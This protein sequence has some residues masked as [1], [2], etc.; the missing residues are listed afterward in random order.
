[1]VDDIR[2]DLLKGQPLGFIEDKFLLGFLP[3]FVFFLVF[4]HFSE[5]FRDAS[6]LCPESRSP[7]KDQQ[8]GRTAKRVG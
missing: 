6:V 4:V 5:F 3:L 2:F 8:V 1:M 7:L